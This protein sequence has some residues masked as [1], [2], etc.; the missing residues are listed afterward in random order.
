MFLI[1][2]KRYELQWAACGIFCTCTVTKVFTDWVL[3]WEAL[4]VLFAMIA[5]KRKLMLRTD[6]FS[7]TGNENLIDFQGFMA[8]APECSRLWQRLNDFKC[9]FWTA[10]EALQCINTLPFWMYTVVQLH[11]LQLLAPSPPSAVSTHT[12]GED[13]IQVLLMVEGGRYV[14]LWREHC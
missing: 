14:G 12:E 6:T 1:A 5:I 2:R 10:P 3:R 8:K 7:A 13:K 4:S 9:Q 11:S